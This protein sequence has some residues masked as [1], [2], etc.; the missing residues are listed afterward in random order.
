MSGEQAPGRGS[1]P[2]WVASLRGA[3]LDQIDIIISRRIQCSGVARAPTYAAYN[4]SFPSPP[5]S[6]YS[7][8]P[9]L[10]TRVTSHFPYVRVHRTNF[11]YKFV[12]VLRFFPHE[13]CL[14]N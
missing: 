8:A 13:G 7:C 4:I 11:S 10:D 1:S 14:F 6:P 5:P 2:R 9:T 3:S 12:A